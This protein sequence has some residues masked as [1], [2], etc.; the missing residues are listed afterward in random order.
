VN[1]W[2]AEVIKLPARYRRHPGGS[3]PHVGTAQ[4]WKWTQLRVAEIRK[5]FS[6]M[7]IR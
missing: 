7:L 2:P 4:I 5:I 6:A 1:S 3:T